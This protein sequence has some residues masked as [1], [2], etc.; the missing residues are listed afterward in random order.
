MFSCKLKKWNKF[1][2]KQDRNF[3]VTNM[4]IYNFK[5]K[6]KP[7]LSCIIILIP[8]DITLPNHVIIAG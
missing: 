1:S 6:S 5:Q 4:N 8:C 7:H 2:I 3:I